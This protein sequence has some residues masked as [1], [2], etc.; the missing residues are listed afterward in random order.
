MISLWFEQIPITCFLCIFAWI[1]SRK[2]IIPD[3][4]SLPMLGL[5]LLKAF[6]LGGPVAQYQTA[7]L[8]F[9]LGTLA[10]LG[11]RGNW[12]G[13]G[14]VKLLAALATWTSLDQWLQLCALSGFLVVL[15]GISFQLLNV[16]PKDRLLEN[17]QK[18]QT[19]PSKT[20]RTYQFHVAFAPHLLLAWLWLQFM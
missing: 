16:I 8:S 10:Y 14:D 15:S 12:L 3:R 6:L 1:D 13:G 2:R 20:N 18:T 4:L 9:A 11:Y 7:T 19:S 17:T 5:G